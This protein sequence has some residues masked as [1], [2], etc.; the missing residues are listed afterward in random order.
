MFVRMT[1][2]ATKMF[3]TH[4]VGVTRSL[5]SLTP[6]IA[7]TRFGRLGTRVVVMSGELSASIRLLVLEKSPA[8]VLT[9]VIPVSMC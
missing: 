1:A 5:L 4:C 7:V 6:L 3:K 8:F 9:N 2:A